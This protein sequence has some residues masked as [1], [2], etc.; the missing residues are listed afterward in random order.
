MAITLSIFPKSANA[1][2]EPSD[3]AQVIAA[4]QPL[5]TLPDTESWIDVTSLTL[6]VQPD[7]S[8]FLN[9]RFK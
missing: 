2:I 6:N 4:I 3:L 7:G 5:I 1:S 8:A 9:I